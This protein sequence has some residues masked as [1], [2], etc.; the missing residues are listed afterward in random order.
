MTTTT[1][2]KL[3][4]CEQA[5]ADFMDRVLE[6]IL[7][8]FTCLADMAVDD[9]DECVKKSPTENEAGKDNIEVMEKLDDNNIENEPKQCVGQ[10]N[11][12][13]VV[14][15]R[16]PN[17]LHYTQFQSVLIAI[18]MVDRQKHLKPYECDFE[19]L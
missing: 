7:N 2:T 8:W 1:T 17:S 5:F 16:H 18:E 15:W 14:K 3:A 10:S 4:P 12:E 9:D 19:V 11:A 13:N 6:C